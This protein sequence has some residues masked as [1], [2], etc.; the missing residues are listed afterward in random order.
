[1]TKNQPVHL[2]DIK[3]VKDDDHYDRWYGSKCGLEYAEKFTYDKTKVTCKRCLKSI[4]KISP[5]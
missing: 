5:K 1:M 3:F 4:N 2:L